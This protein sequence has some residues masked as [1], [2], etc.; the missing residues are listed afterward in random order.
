MVSHRESEQRRIDQQAEF[1]EAMQITESEREAY[2]LLKRHLE[3]SVAAAEMTVLSRNNS[4]DRLEPR[5]PP[6]EALAARLQDAKPRS[7]MAVRTGEQQSHGNGREPLLECE[8]CGKLGPS[9]CQPLLVG[10]EVMGSVLALPQRSLDAEEREA[11]RVSVAQAAPILANLRNLAIA[12]QRAG[13]DELTGLANQRAAGDAVKRLV[14]DAVKS[15]QPLGAIVLDLDHFKQVNDVFGH[16]AGDEV[17]AA[18]GVALRTTI[19]ETDFCARWGG[20][21]FLVLLPQTDAEGTQTAAE[22]IRAAIG[23]ITVPAVQR[24][25]SASLGVAALPLHAVDAAALV[26]CARP[27][28]L[29][30]QGGWTQPRRD[31]RG[32]R[33][34]RRQGL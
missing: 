6:G 17:L 14:A 30:R 28:A 24:P 10:G 2:E 32:A 23:R 16:A 34:K 19:H 11:M 5:T 12:E 26:R 21:E 8:V 25:I 1:S 20:E 22:N 4:A 31:G 13:T 33:A 9:A 27:S 29:H 7:C 18:V 3:R 15:G